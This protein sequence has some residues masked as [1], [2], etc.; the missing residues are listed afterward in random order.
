MA[1]QKTS[2]RPDTFGDMVTF[3]FGT[4]IGAAIGIGIALWFAPRSGKETRHD[5][6][7]RGLELRAQAEQA[8]AQTR[9]KIDGPSTERLLS[10]AKAAARQYRDAA[11]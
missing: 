10:E 6:Q 11:G 4:L 9:E 8:A 3:A 5:I 2:E 7:A 1:R